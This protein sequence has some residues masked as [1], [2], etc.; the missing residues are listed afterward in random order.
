MRALAL[1]LALSLIATPVWAASKPKGKNFD[2]ALCAKDIPCDVVYDDDAISRLIT[3]ATICIS[4]RFGS[5]AKTE[6][7]ESMGF[8]S[9]KC[10]VSKQ[11]SKKGNASV[12]TSYCCLHPIEDSDGLC[13]LI[14]EQYVT[15]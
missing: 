7:D 15:R 6:F 10:L 5:A 8:D 12:S 1:I 14:C 9:N 4:R 2:T 11:K 13:E 3:Q